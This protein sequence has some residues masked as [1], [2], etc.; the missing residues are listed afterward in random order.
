MLAWFLATDNSHT[1][2]DDPADI[3]RAE[4]PPECPHCGA[5]LYPY[6]ALIGS[7]GL[8]EWVEAWHCPVHGAVIQVD[9]GNNEADEAK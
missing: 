7:W 4:K 1:M 2:P 9:Q 3:V 8:L 5:S 6:G